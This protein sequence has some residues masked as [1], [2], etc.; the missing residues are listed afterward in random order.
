MIRYKRIR[1]DIN[2]KDHDGPSKIIEL[3][4]DVFKNYSKG[5]YSI[6]NILKK[7]N[8]NITTINYFINEISI[9]KEK[10]EEININ[11]IYCNLL[12]EKNDLYLK[13]YVPVLRN[14]ASISKEK[15]TVQDL[16][17]VTNFLFILIIARETLI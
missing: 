10:L 3:F 14:G 8:N 7:I 6:D 5:K 11:S 15:L 12:D 2:T 17:M 9:I 1:F 4:Y 13:K 16:P